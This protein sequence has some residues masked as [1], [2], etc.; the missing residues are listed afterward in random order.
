[1]QPMK[2]IRSSGKK[3]RGSRESR[4]TSTDDRNLF[5]CLWAKSETRDIPQQRE[6]VDRKWMKLLGWGGFASCW[7]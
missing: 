4:M 5:D 1:M 2:V 7:T 6:L 3:F